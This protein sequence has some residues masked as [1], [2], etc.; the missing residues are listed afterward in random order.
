MCPMALRFEAFDI[1]ARKRA[2]GKIQPVL[3]KSAV[4]ELYSVVDLG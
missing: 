4:A 3:S 1:I 2:F